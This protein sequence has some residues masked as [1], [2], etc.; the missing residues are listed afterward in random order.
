[1]AQDPVPSRVY[2]LH[3]VGG[4]CARADTLLF[5]DYRI[6][7]PENGTEKFADHRSAIR[8][9]HLL[10]GAISERCQRSVFK[11][12]QSF[13]PPASSKSTISEASISSK[14]AQ[15]RPKSRP[16]TSS[17]D[18][19]QSFDIMKTLRS[20]LQN[21]PFRRSTCSKIALAF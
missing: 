1:M 7:P 11:K 9:P 21:R 6:T 10:Y 17:L 8:T 3:K 14:L 12:M 15:T 18:H 16:H 5:N 4:S 13:P 19:V 20:F 2:F